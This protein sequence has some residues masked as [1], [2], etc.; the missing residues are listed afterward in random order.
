MDAGDFEKEENSILMNDGCFS[1]QRSIEINFKL[2][3]WLDQLITSP[4]MY[5]S[6]LATAE[7]FHRVYIVRNDLTI[8]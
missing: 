7:N 4:S 8:F 1:S 3:L 6:D 5:F 2:Q